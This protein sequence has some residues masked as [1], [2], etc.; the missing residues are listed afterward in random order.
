VAVSVIDVLP[1]R[2]VHGRH[3]LVRRDVALDQQRQLL[4]EPRVGGRVE[5]RVP[6]HRDLGSDRVRLLDRARVQR[7]RVGR[8]RGLHRRRRGDR[9]RDRVDLGVP[10]ERELQE[11]PDQRVVRLGVD[12]HADPGS[13]DVLVVRGD[14]TVDRREGEVVHVV[15]HARVE[16]LG[17][18]VAQLPGPDVVDGGL[19]R[20]EQRLGV[21]VAG[22]GEA[23]LEAPGLPELGQPLGGG[24]TC[25]VRERRVAVLEVLDVL[26]ACHAERVV[27]HVPL[28]RPLVLAVERDRRDALGA[29]VP[30][31]L[32]E[33]VEARGDRDARLLEQCGVVPEELE[34]ELER[35]H[36]QRAVVEPLVAQ[37]GLAVV[38]RQSEVVEQG[39]DVD[40]PVLAR[41]LLREGR[42]VGVEEL[43]ELVRGREGLVLLDV[44][45][46][47]R[48]GDEV[49]R[50]SGVL[51]SVLVGDLFHR[52]DHAAVSRSREEP[53][54]LARCDLALGVD[55]GRVGAAGPAG[56]PGE[57]EGG[58]HGG[59][60]ECCVALPDGHGGNLR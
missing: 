20:R 29:Q 18:E 24:D 7:G 8:D 19:P 53:G 44:G 31:E 34:L 60:E 45:R 6:G 41:E 35:H 37:S 17:R 42:G 47:V 27:G 26:R 49:Q 1:Q 38:L 56:A 3:E 28:E 54:D 36:V 58:G 4:L 12:R 2:R 32:R 10:L 14:R 11:V 57:C 22:G 33:V 52:G 30:A 13:R 40:H 5:L 39:V 23:L 21:G 16:R 59:G 48:C 25:G 9:T 55:V 51:G 43:R 50:E 46:P 15:A